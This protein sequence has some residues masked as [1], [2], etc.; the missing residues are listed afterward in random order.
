MFSCFCFVK[1]KFTSLLESLKGKGESPLFLIF[2]MKQ[3]GDPPGD[4]YLFPPPS[5]NFC[6]SP[7]F[8]HLPLVLIFLMKLKEK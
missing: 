8:P 3:D 1:K 5:T 4:L 2:N 7:L 6:Q